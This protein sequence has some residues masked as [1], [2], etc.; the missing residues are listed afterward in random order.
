MRDQGEM[1]KWL[2][3]HRLK[4]QSLRQLRR[5]LV[6]LDICSILVYLFVLELV[7]PREIPCILDQDFAGANAGIQLQQGPRLEKIFKTLVENSTTAGLVQWM[8]G[9]TK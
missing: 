3:T 5:K 6:C 7:V 9:T 8:A 4:I 2:T 1:E